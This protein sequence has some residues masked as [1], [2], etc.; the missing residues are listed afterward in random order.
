MN[1]V[2]IGDSFEGSCFEI[3]TNSLNRDELGLL[4]QQCKIFQ[5]KGYYSKD[6][7]K[8]IIFDL[9]IEVWPPKANRYSL[10][11][12]IECKDYR[13]KPVPV[14]DLEE[15]YAKVVQVSGV[16]TKAVFITSNTFQSGAYTYANSKGMM[17]IEVND[18]FTYSI[19]LHKT[20]RYNNRLLESSIRKIDNSLIHENIITQLD[21]RKDFLNLDRYILS[22]FI[23]YLKQ[24]S[25]A[26]L[27]SNLL[28]YSRER[29][30]EIT[31]QLLQ[32]FDSNCISENR[33][34]RIGEIFQKLNDVFDLTISH[35]N[36]IE[37][38]EQER[39]IISKCSF[40][41]KKITIDKSIINSNRYNFIL[42]HELGHFFLHNKVQIKQDTYEK[43]DDSRQSFILDRYLLEN[44][45]N[46]MEWQANQ[47]ATS[48]LMPREPFYFQFSKFQDQ[49]GLRPG[50]QLYVDRQKCNQDSLHRIASYLS[51]LFQVSKTSIIY[52]LNSLNLLKEESNMKHLSQII[53]EMMREV[54]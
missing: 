8:E 53:R 45:R 21:L 38:D 29:I 50:A 14:D 31:N 34:P 16:N 41:E 30:D 1:T 39:V 4:S 54:D 18:N 12:L 10:L 40:L 32:T 7:E 52:R 6:R 46:W 2:K 28:K 13:S 11:Y 25:N 9:S 36:I 24:T 15:F 23:D 42:A 27:N 20:R 22:G 37:K 19:I 48:F 44:E 49:I 26:K 17:L 43:L 3:I 47:F 51:I 35:E 33:L 5:K